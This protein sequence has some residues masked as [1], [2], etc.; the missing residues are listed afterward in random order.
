M[1]EGSKGRQRFTPLYNFARKERGNREPNAVRM[2]ETDSQVPVPV[3]NHRRYPVVIFFVLGIV[4]L[5]YLIISAFSGGTS[6]V[7][8][9]AAVPE[10]RINARDSGPRMVALQDGTADQPGP[11]QSASSASSALSADNGEVHEDNVRRV[12][13]VQMSVPEP[14]TL[15]HE[16]GSIDVAGINLVDNGLKY[17][18]KGIVHKNRDEF[19]LARRE[20]EK[21]EDQFARTLAS[22]AS[23]DAEEQALYYLG[24]LYFEKNQLERAIDYFLLASKLNPDN[25]Y[26]KF[27]LAS[28]YFAMGFHDK[29]RTLFEEVLEKDSSNSDAPYYLGL[30]YS[31]Q[32][33]IDRAV[34]YLENAARVDPTDKEVHMKLG[35][36]YQ[37]QQKFENA[38][39]QYK[40]ALVLDPE[41]GLACNQIGSI[42]Y[43]MKDYQSSIKWHK[44]AI[45]HDPEMVE[46]YYNLGCAYQVSGEPDRAAIYFRRVLELN[47]DFKEAAGLKSFLGKMQK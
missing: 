2:G 16:S 38:I 45:H 12:V 18:K 44:K 6:N 3:A 26:T 21:A 5:G 32:K 39:S 37:A 28:I 35:A 24:C 11:G 36:L 27:N 31:A 1:A 20:F 13:P 22:P 8:S 19:D 29:A 34:S 33:N 9:N 10:I 25:V 15:S 47:P 30:I 46:G 23:S 42:Y 14:V 7:S 40:K 43:L 17:L 41:N 4:G